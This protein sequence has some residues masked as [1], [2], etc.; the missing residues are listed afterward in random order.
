WR[1]SPV[2]RDDV[3]PRG[4]DP[5]RRAG[6]GDLPDGGRSGPPGGAVVRD[7]RAAARRNASSGAAAVCGGLSVRHALLTGASGFIGSEFL[8]R[9]VAWAPEVEL[10]VLVRDKRRQSAE[11]RV[12]ALCGDL[13]GADAG[14]VLARIRVVA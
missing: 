6:A 8:R 11:E 13:F 1:S 9:L 12:S 14:R 2:H 10:S 7:Y 4:A 5:A 3:C